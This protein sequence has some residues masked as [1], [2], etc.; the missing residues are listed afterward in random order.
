MNAD[1]PRR[2]FPAAVPVVC[3]AVLVA[4]SSGTA[5]AAVGSSKLHASTPHR[6]LVLAGTWSGRYGGAYS[7]TFRLKWTQTG[8]RLRGSITLS[9]PHGTYSVT[10]S[11][12]GTAIKFG[13]VSVGATY[14][15]SVSGKKMSGRYKTPGGGGSWSAHKSS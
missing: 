9:K 1:S 10:G 4:I 8:S 11:V 5:L 15:G 3:A 14:T 6:G 13:A 2:G 7:G 12:H